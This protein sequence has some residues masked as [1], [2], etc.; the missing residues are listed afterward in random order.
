MDKH[1]Q[2]LRQ[3]VADL[4][5]KA[6]EFNNSGKYKDAKAKIEEA[7]NAKNEFDNYL[8]MKQIQVPAPVNSQTGALPPSPVNNE[9]SEI[10]KLKSGQDLKITEAGII[11]DLNPNAASV[12]ENDLLFITQAQLDEGKTGVAL[13]QVKTIYVE[14]TSGQNDILVKNFYKKKYGQNSLDGFKGLFTDLFA[15]LTDICSSK[16]CS[17]MSYRN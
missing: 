6:E 1:E 12:A 17:C 10:H 9:D 5:A 4:K 13:N 11:V 14:K 2:E 8:A 3:K 16:S 15:H 7:Q